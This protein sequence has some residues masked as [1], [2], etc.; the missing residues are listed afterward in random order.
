M[1]LIEPWKHIFECKI[2]DSYRSDSFTNP[3][4]PL[5]L[6]N[7]CFMKNKVSSEQKEKTTTQT[8]TKKIFNEKRFSNSQLIQSFSEDHN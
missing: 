4:L 1:L 7:I 3:H 8:K 2:S 6:Y 5:F